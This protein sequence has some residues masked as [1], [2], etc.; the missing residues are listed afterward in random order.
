MPVNNDRILVDLDT[1]APSECPYCGGSKN[2]PWGSEL[3]FTLVRCCECALLYVSPLPSGEIVDEAV[4]TGL[5]EQLGLNVTSRRIPRKKFMYEGHFRNLFSDLINWDRPLTWVDVGCGYG[6]VLEAVREIVPANSRVLG[7]EPM[8]HKA[9]N[10]RSLGL[11][12]INDYLTPGVIKADVISVVDIFSHIPDFHS[13]LKV[14]VSNLT[15]TGL[16]FIETG[17]LADLD[18]REQFSGELG[19]PDHLVFSGEA[20]LRGYLQKAGFDI[21]ATE[22]ERTDTLIDFTK[23][24]AKRLLGRPVR[25]SIPY[26]SKYRQIRIRARLKPSSQRCI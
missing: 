13:F 16:I 12:V 8:R 19:L 20:T 10:A 17:N 23:N 22:Y 25:L 21:E 9:M 7:F 6:E 26:T 1:G 4:R 11:E 18:T 2:S 5:H 14:V 24:I 3:G 15:E